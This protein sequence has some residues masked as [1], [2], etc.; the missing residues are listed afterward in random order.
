MVDKTNIVDKATKE[1]R[2]ARLKK[3]G[4]QKGVSGNPAGKP[5]GTKNFTTLFKEAVKKLAKE[6]VEGASDAE[7]A[8]VMTA[9][10]EA[11]KG[12]FNFYKDIIDR[13]YGKSKDVVDLESSSLVELLT[14]LNKNEP[15]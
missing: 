4:F 13:M 5:L 12:N 14:R 10:K 8:L 3:Q 7:K 2:L 15:K 11:H 1:E 6:G 9:F